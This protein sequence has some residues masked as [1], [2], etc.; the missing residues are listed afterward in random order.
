MNLDNWNFAEWTYLDIAM[1]G[2]ALVGIGFLF[3]KLLP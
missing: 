3:S 1:F 2:F